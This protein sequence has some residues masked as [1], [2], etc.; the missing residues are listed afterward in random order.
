MIPGTNSLIGQ[1]LSNIWFFII[2]LDAIRIT[3]LDTNIVVTCQDERSQLKNKQKAL[4]LITQKVNKYY[5]DK[6]QKE[7]DSIRKSIKN[8]DGVIR[9]YDIA[10]NELFDTRTQKKY[11]ISDVFKDEL[12]DIDSEILVN[13]VK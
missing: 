2:L 4:E 8:K 5:L 3:H 7:I 1:R 9:T 13:E 12:G 10:K 11:N 6:Q